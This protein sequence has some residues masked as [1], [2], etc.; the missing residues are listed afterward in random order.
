TRE[1]SA[2][3]A[4]VTGHTNRPVKARGESQIIGPGSRPG[5]LNRK[6]VYIFP[7]CACTDGV[8]GYRRGVKNVNFSSKAAEGGFGRRVAISGSVGAQYRR[9]VRYGLTVEL[10]VAGGT[11]IRVELREN[12]RQADS[13]RRSREGEPDHQPCRNR[14]CALHNSS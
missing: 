3:W 6:E 11:Y 13:I 8:S 1:A 2:K 5:N 7:A 12:I 10:V 14:D 4:R 9:L